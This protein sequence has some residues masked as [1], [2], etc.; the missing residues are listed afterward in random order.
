MTKYRVEYRF[1]EEVEADNSREAVEEALKKEC[2]LEWFVH[3]D[4]S[5]HIVA[6]ADVY[7]LTDE[8]EQ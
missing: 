3:N 1:Y 4:I 8:E 6:N 2:N 7:Q 5:E